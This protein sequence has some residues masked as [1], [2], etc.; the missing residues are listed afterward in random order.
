MKILLVEDNKSY[1]KM[2]NI[3]LLRAGHEV[4]PLEIY[5][6]RKLKDFMPDLVITDL[7]MPETDGHDVIKSVKNIFNSIPVWVLSSNHNDVNVYKGLAL[8]ADKYLFK[9]KSISEVLSDIEMMDKKSGLPL[10]AYQYKLSEVSE[11]KIILNDSDY[12]TVEMNEEPELYS[13]LRM[14]TEE[15][16]NDQ[17]VRV[18][19]VYS[20]EGRTRVRCRKKLT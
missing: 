10:K 16:K 6:E 7:M 13:I 14:M 12:L 17:F 20:W 11:V 1:R 15:S 8:G 18:E 2:L 3:N 5:D 4:M 9:D 19:D